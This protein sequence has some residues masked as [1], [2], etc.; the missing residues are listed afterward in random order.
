MKIITIAAQK[1]GVAKTTTAFNLAAELARRGHQVAAVDLDTQGSFALWG[2]SRPA[3][4]PRIPVAPVT[5]QTVAS[6]IKAAEGDGFDW[7]VIDTPPTRAAGDLDTAIARADLVLVPVTPSGIDI[8]ACGG[9]VKLVRKLG[10]PLAIILSL[11]DPKL[12]GSFERSWVSDARKALSR[13]GELYPG[14][15][16]K[17]RAYQ[18]AFVT[19]L[20]VTEADDDAAAVKEIGALTDWITSR[21]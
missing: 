12:A 9:T 7:L 4:R 15:V 17:R 20:G 8:A 3:D 18:R 11:A 6:A 10:R 1:G 2:K 5:S 21:I 19:G 13:L 14:C 16:V